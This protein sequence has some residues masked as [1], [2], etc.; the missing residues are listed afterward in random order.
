[1]SDATRFAEVFQ[2]CLRMLAISDCVASPAQQA[3][4]GGLH[5]RL[6]GAR[7]GAERAIALPRTLG[8]VD[9]SFIRDASAMT[10]ALMGPRCHVKAASLSRGCLGVGIMS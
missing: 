10:A 6:P 4:R 1:S 9:I 8:E 2:R 7:F 3:E 5:E